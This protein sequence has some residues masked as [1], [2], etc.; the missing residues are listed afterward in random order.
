[1]N[2][3]SPMSGMTLRRFLT[4]GSHSAAKQKMAQLCGPASS[5]YAGTENMDSHQTEFKTEF[6]A[7][8]DDKLIIDGL[9]NL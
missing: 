4:S 5:T 8:L 9:A 7:F 1:M 2:V 6:A 3:K